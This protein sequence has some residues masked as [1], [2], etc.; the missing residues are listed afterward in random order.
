MKKKAERYGLVILKPDTHKDLIVEKIIGDIR[1]V[2]FRIIL[3]KDIHITREQAE[4]IYLENKDDDSYPYAISSL[5]RGKITLLIVEHFETGALQRLKQLKGKANQGGLR[6]KYASYVGEDTKEKIN[7]RLLRYK[8]AQNRLH[9]PDS[10]E[11]MMRIIKGLLT[12]KEK[13]VLFTKTF[14]N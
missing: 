14:I 11:T 2:G 12:L 1:K 3:R 5:L 6:K 9:V 8:M 10:T 13:V 4:L 7:K